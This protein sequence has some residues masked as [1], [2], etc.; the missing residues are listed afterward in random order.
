MYLH[1]CF[2]PNIYLAIYTFGVTHIF[3][4]KHKEIHIRCINCYLSYCKKFS[5]CKKFTFDKR[6]ILNHLTMLIPTYSI[7]QYMFILSNHLLIL[8]LLWKILNL[9][10]I[11]IPYWY[12]NFKIFISFNTSIQVFF[13]E[14]ETFGLGWYAKKLI[15]D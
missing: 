2:W 7:F 9:D 3:E 1:E 12:Y 8:V 11:Y 6:S 10:H 13:N 5:K 14:I 4:W 15:L